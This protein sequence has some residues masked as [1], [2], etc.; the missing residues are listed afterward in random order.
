[1]KVIALKLST[2]EDIL[3]ELESQSE[4]D[5]VLTNP[6]AISV[7]RDR[8]GQPAIGLSPFPMHSEMSNPK[9]PGFK[10]VTFPISRKFVVYSYTPAPDYTKQ[11]NDIFGSGI[12]LPPTPKQ[13]I[14]G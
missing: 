4:T 13:V 1:M 6:V 5:I 9:E 12:L 10:E 2:G 8:T 7:M 14:L 3:G 11:Y